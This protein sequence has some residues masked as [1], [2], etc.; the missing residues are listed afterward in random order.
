[1]NQDPEKKPEISWI[2]FI[3]LSALVSAICIFI[4][5]FMLMKI[6]VPIQNPTTDENKNPIQIQ[7][8]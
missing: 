1:M 4:L 5:S 8:K 6:P 3:L 7:I 2:N